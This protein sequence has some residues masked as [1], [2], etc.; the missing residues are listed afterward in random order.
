[1]AAMAAEY[2]VNQWGHYRKSSL[3]GTDEDDRV[4]PTP[5][6]Q[7]AAANPPAT[8]RPPHPR[9]T[10]TPRHPIHPPN[11]PTHHIHPT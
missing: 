11:P 3:V 9:H 6:R 10:P 1:M 7:S 2:H 8:L 5:Y 4:P